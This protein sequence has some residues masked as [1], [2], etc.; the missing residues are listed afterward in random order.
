MP[1]E[2]SSFAG[3]MPAIAAVVAVAL[4]VGAIYIMNAKN[5]SPAEPA[6]SSGQ[7]ISASPSQDAK[8]QLKIEILKTGTG[9]QAKAGDVV[10]VNYTGYLTDGT[11]FD[12]SLDRNQ[13]F[14]FTLGA[15]QVIAGWDQGVAGMNIGERR[16]L[17]IP[18]TLAYGETGTPG[19]P[20]P[21]NA[22]L[23]FEIDLLKIG[24]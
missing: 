5:N 21:P 7:A 15:Q 19:G 17:T 3:K 6:S 8:P 2:K 13:P 16:R 20:I 22:T 23:I 4:V 1:Q 14:S 11:K 24:A 12:S 10:T 9:A 18:P